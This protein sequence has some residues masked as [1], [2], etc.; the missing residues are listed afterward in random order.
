MPSLPNKNMQQHIFKFE[1]EPQNNS[2]A[3]HEASP[4]FTISEKLERY[5]TNALSVEEHLVLLV[6]KQSNATALIQYLGSV[7]ALSRATMVE[8]RQFLPKQK[9]EAVMAALSIAN[10]ASVEEAAQEPLESPERV[11]MF[12]SDM[13]AL[14]QEVLRVILLDA[15]F[16]TITKVDIFKGSLNESLAHPREIFRAAIVHSAYALVVAHN[17]PFGDPSPSEADIRLTRRL[18]EAAR[19]LQI[20]L[21]DHVIVGSAIA[22]GSPYFQLQG[23]R[24]YRMKDAGASALSVFELDESDEP[25]SLPKEN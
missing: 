22:G 3:A 21:V 20:Q 11:Y 16:R 25:D 14:N 13:L 7:R 12:C 19:I 1:S 8:L 10:M 18:S 15:R 24:C 17:H 6:G 2:E 23:R 5:G 9:A 4:S